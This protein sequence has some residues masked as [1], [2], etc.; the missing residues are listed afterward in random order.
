MWRYLKTYCDSISKVITSAVNT[1]HEI[2]Q[3]IKQLFTSYDHC[4]LR[5]AKGIASHIKEAN[6]KHQLEIYF[7]HIL[8]MAITK[9][10]YYQRINKL[11]TALAILESVDHIFNK[12]KESL[13]P[14]SLH[15]CG[16][17]I[18]SIG[19]VYMDCISPKAAIWYLLN[20]LTYFSTE[21]DILCKDKV[22]LHFLRNDAK[23]A[24]FLH[25]NVK[26]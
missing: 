19:N 5:W 1:Q 12:L 17:Y 10:L 8:L 13:N 7:Q 24:Y 6:I 3:P 4:M 11:S 15:I 18:M 22:Q 9:A 16:R 23:K 20:A 21:N 26:V 25:K 14:K 2:S